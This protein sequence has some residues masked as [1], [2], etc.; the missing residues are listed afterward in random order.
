MYT[1]YIDTSDVKYISSMFPLIHR[2]NFEVVYVTFQF[3]IMYLSVFD[4]T[5]LPYGYIYMQ[6]LIY[7]IKAIHQL[8]Y[9]IIR[10]LHFVD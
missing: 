4:N 6:I 8:V 9:T 5:Y 1:F 10:C 3:T 2:V 7:F